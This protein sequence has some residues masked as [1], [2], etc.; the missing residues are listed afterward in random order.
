MLYFACLFNE[1]LT[2]DTSEASPQTHKHVA[3]GYGEAP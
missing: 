3:F 1:F 2:Q